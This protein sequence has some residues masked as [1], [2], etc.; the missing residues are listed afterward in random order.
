MLEA[1]L[2]RGPDEHPDPVLLVGDA[3]M[4]K[5]AL[6]DSLAR[7]ARMRG[8]RVVRAAAPQGAE[9]T[10][11]GVVEDIARALHGTFQRLP[12]DDAAILRT[13][14]RSDHRAQVRWC[15]PCCTCWPRLGMS[16]RC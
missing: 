3:G 11:F 1:T 7:R 14:P 15:R 10:S 9:A 13:H 2:D 4:G 16:S 12:Q 8:V 5:S 6:L